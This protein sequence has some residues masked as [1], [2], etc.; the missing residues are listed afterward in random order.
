[1]FHPVGRDADRAG[2]RN[3]SYFSQ[4]VRNLK[5]HNSLDDYVSYDKHDGWTLN[6]NGN[7]LLSRHEE[8]VRNIFSVLSDD[9]FSYEDKISFLQKLTPQIL[10]VGTRRRLGLVKAP[11]TSTKGKRA[12]PSKKIIVYNED[13]LISGEG[14]ESLRTVKVRQRSAKLREAAIQKYSD[15][16]GRIKCSICGFEFESVYDGLGKGYIEIHHIKP[17]YRY[18]SEDE[19]TFV[20]KALENLTPVCA[21]CHRMLHRKKDISYE[22]VQKI[23]NGDIKI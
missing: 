23:Y 5:S 19:N 15:S 3:D 13:D 20:C 14:K 1:M 9:S 7:A 18:E 22:D 8:D 4:I 6:D 11:I 2:V 16:S 12:L 10:P 17:I 21:N